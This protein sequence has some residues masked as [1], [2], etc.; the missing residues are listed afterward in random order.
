MFHIWTEQKL[1]DILK[2]PTPNNKPGKE[3]KP[4]YYSRVLFVTTK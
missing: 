2:T 4:P 3:Y 1:D